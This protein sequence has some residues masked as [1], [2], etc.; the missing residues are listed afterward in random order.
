[1]I[2]AFFEEKELVCFRPEV[3]GVTGDVSVEKPGV[4]LARSSMKGR[5]QYRGQRVADTSIHRGLVSEFSNTQ[6]LVCFVRATGW[7]ASCLA[8][9][10]VINVITRFRLYP[11]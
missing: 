6:L 9:S 5:I 2:K 8:F 10:C 1:M 4:L 3:N 7:N 11:M